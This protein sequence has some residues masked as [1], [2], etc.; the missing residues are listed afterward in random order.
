ME[1]IGC[2]SFHLEC[3]TTGR[4]R[5]N[6]E[7]VKINSIGEKMECWLWQT[8]VSTPFPILYQMKQKGLVTVEANYPTEQGEQYLFEHWNDR[9]DVVLIL[10]IIYILQ[11]K[12]KGGRIPPDEILAI[13][14]I[15]K[16][17]HKKWLK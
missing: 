2:C 12:V 11:M 1:R 16:G 14:K 9:N 3:Q 7:Q 17:D 15:M 5:F 13:A 8:T 10:N 4:C 6:Q